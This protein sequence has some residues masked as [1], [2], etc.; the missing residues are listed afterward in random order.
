MMEELVKV[1]CILL[2]SNIVVWFIG[3]YLCSENATNCNQ[4]CTNTN[5]S[6]ICSCFD[7]YELLSDNATC[8]G[9][10]KTIRVTYII[11]TLL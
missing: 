4:I 11:T 8:Q 9:N 5:N 7:G 1:N 3:V 6:F 10:I 2:R